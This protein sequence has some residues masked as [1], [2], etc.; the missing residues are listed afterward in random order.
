[1]PEEKY[2]YEAKTWKNYPNTS[3]PLNA[4]N[5]QYMD[6]GIAKAHERLNAVD[7]I[8]VSN[9][10]ILTNLEET[11]QDKLTSGA[12]VT[13]TD[14][15]IISVSVS[16][17]VY[18]TEDTL[19]TEDNEVVVGEKDTT[20]IITHSGIS[21]NSLLGKQNLLT[22]GNAGINLTNDIISLN[23]NFIFETLL[24]NAKHESDSNQAYDVQQWINK[25]SA[26]NYRYFTVDFFYKD[27]DPKQGQTL[28]IDAQN[29]I[30]T[31]DQSAVFALF[32]SDYTY[33]L[34]NTM[35]YRNGYIHGRNI[36]NDSQG[37]T[38]TKYA[39]YVTRIQ[40]VR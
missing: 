22:V 31:R 19:F 21:L 35:V 15:N 9:I 11:K 7:E 14:D 6:N 39:F 12:G 10:E 23:T 13:I 1:M 32:G 34:L 33:V 37:H 27:F 26:V 5:L 25:D 38:S 18:P 17:G 36:S 30:N 40:G 8:L 2:I 20:N 28:W 29:V 4:D 16:S 24:E 3:T